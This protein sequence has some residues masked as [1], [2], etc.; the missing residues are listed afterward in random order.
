MK[1]IAPG[2]AQKRSPIG[3]FDT[4]G[5]DL[6]THR[7]AQGNNRGDDCRR[8]QRMTQ[9]LNEALV[10]LDSVDLEIAQVAK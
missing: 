7:V 8:I 5:C 9:A 1:Q 4:F 3:G 6:Q 2:A 10:D